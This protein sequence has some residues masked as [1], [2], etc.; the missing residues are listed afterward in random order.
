MIEVFQERVHSLIVN[1]QDW[2]FLQELALIEGKVFQKRSLN[3]VFLL[4][5][6][7]TEKFRLQAIFFIGPAVTSRI[8]KLLSFLPE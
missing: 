3:L 8:V 7:L 2:F 4:N 1:S 5:F 6:S